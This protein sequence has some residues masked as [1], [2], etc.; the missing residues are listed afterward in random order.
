MG[1]LNIE[2][3]GRIPSKKNSKRWVIA[4]GKRFL[5]PSK[6]YKLWHEEQMWELKKY[7]VKS[8]IKKC[9]IWVKIAFPDK[10]KADLSNKI[11]SINDL[12]VDA[13]ILE[14]DD[15]RILTGLYIDSLGVDPKNP[16]AII[17][18]KIIN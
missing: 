2:L 13:Y 14:D 3:K 8:P 18:I 11:E 5:V 9:R 15:H 1:E 6:E 10:R 12:L 7:K 17:K 16:R 4:G